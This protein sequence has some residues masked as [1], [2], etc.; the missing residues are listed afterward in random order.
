M[1]TSNPQSQLFARWV[2]LGL[3]SGLA[4]MVQLV[5]GIEHVSTGRAQDTWRSL[6]LIE[7]NWPLA[8]VLF[9]LSLT[10][11]LGGLWLGYR[12]WRQPD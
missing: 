8:L 5:S 6:W 12:Q 9:A 4:L 1:N 2:G 10:G 7:F 11:I 3:L